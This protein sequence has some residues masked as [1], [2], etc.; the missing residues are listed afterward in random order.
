MLVRVFYN[1]HNSFTITVD[2]EIIDTLRLLGKKIDCFFITGVLRTI[3]LKGFDVL[4][5][6]CKLTESE[7]KDGSGIDETSTFDEVG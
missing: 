6:E 5:T 7:V 1:S 3:I 2:E 4:E